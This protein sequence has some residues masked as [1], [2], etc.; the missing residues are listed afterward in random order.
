[1]VLVL[2]VLVMVTVIIFVLLPRNN[3]KNEQEA[4]NSCLRIWRF[5]VNQLMY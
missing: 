4:I 3:T 5:T 1:M 2:A